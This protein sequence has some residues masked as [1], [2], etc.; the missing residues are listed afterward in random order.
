MRGRMQ[1]A[2]LMATL[3]C[4]LTTYARTRPRHPDRVLFQRAMCALEHN[5]VD[6][7]RL[8]IQTLVNTYPNSRAAKKAKRL[9]ARDP[10]LSKCV[11]WSVPADA[12]DPNILPSPG[13]D[14]PLQMVISGESSH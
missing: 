14:A 6:V 7:A 8:T 3:V 13:A 4:G 9:L 1:I 10:I 2:I 12:C 5:H 11:A